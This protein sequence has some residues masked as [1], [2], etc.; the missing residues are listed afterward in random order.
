MPA[1][2][3]YSGTFWVET[4]AISKVTLD[5]QAR[6]MRAAGMQERGAA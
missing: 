6:I 5:L 1:G 4:L 2:Q 3:A